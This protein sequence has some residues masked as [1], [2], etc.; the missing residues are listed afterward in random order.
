MNILM[1]LINHATGSLQKRM[2]TLCST[3]IEI[4]DMKNANLVKLSDM[5]LVINLK[6][7][8]HF[9]GGSLIPRIKE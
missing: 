3:L 5:K 9:I 6:S 8:P 4:E 2:G 1:L 7:S